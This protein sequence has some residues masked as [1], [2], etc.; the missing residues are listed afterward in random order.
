MEIGTRE[1]VLGLTRQI[2]TIRDLPRV[3]R[4]LWSFGLTDDQREL[5]KQSL[6]TYIMSQVIGG[7][8]KKRNQEEID[9][10]LNTKPL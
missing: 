5:A 2:R 3:I 7:T 8:I 1:I 4:A 6:R 10:I 9:K